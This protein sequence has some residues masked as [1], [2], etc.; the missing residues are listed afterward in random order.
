MKKREFLKTSAILGAGALL[1]PS[2]I[3]SCSNTSAQSGVALSLAPTGEGGKSFSPIWVMP[4]MPWSP[5]WMP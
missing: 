5:M 3:S 2:M 1:A 4:M